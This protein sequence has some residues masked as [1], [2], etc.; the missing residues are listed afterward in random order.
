MWSITQNGEKGHI[1]VEGLDKDSG[2]MNFLNVGGE[3]V[4]PTGTQSMNT[5]CKPVP[6]VTKATST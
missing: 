6:V 1:V 2:F 5:W 3:V 4:A